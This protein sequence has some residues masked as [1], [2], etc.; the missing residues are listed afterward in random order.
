M[1][2]DKQARLS[3]FVIA[4][5]GASGSGKSALVK[6]LVHRL[7]DAVALHFDDYSPRYFP[8]S[9]YPDDIA[10]WI[11]DGA[12]PSAW[13]TPQLVLDLRAIRQG[14]SITLPGYK[15]V[16]KPAT[17]IMRA[18]GRRKP[19][20][21]PRNE[22]ILGPATYIVIEEPFG[23][24]REGMK[25]LIDF[26]I[27]L[28]TP[29][30]VAL[31]RRLLEIPEIPYFIEHPN[32]QYPTMLE[33]LR[34]YLYSSGRDLYIAVNEQ[35]RKNCDLVLDGMKSIDELAEEAAAHVHTAA[36]SALTKIR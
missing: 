17:F 28:D 14:K 23:R 25:E 1:E 36:S 9:K 21:F 5:S 3:C 32:E 8:T 7:G 20:V 19:L 13:E 16:S 34:G 22:R 11:A 30:E 24:E 2:Q 15:E 35:V 27:A 6:A 31:A 10:K 4:I 29:L 12:D 26:V 33:F 18:L